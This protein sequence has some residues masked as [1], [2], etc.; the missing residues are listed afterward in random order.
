MAAAFITSMFISFPSLSELAR[1]FI[2]QIPKGAPG[3]QAGL[4]ID[5]LSGLHRC[6][7]TS[8]HCCNFLFNLQ[9]NHYEGRNQQLDRCGDPLPDNGLFTLCK[10]T[11]DKGSDR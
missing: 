7:F 11:W 8:F 3:I 4:S 9:K 1:G 10:C 6:N 2:P 5:H